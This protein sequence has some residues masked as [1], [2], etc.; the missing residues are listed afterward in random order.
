MPDDKPRLGPFLRQYAN[1]E[2]KTPR[3]RV[4]EVLLGGAA[5]I[6]MLVVLVGVLL[7]FVR[8]PLL[9]L[10]GLIAV[11]GIGFVVLMVK[12]RRADARDRDLRESLERDG[13]PQG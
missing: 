4:Q 8:F 9:T 11:W 13:A 6:G 7:A 12:K 5:A 2:T 10:G 3:E 1:S